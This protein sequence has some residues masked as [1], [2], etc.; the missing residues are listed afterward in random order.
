VCTYY[1]Y[2]SKLT[3]NWQGNLAEA[4]AKTMI[5]EKLNTTKIAYQKKKIPAWRLIRNKNKTIVHFE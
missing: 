1:Q 4:N 2:F 5:R 3:L